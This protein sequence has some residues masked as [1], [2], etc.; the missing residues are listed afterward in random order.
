MRN[1]LILALPT[2][3][4]CMGHAIVVAAPV[5]RDTLVSG[6][7]WSTYALA[8]TVALMAVAMMM[9]DV[10]AALGTVVESVRSS[11]HASGLTAVTSGIAA[12]ADVTATMASLGLFA[13]TGSVR[14]C[15]QH[16]LH[17]LLPRQEEV[18]APRTRRML[19][20]DSTR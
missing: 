6:A 12:L 17:R 2:P 10:S 11:T 9:G 14:H 7:R 15:R 4:D 5:T 8:W 20:T 19:P 13:K 16:Q 18:S 1:L 3:A